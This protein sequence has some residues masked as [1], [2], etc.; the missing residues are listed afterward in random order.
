MLRPTALLFWAPL[1][2]PRLY[3]E[4]TRRGPLH[5]ARLCLVP[6]LVAVAA[7]AADFLFY[8]Q[9]T[10]TPYN[11]FKVNILHNLGSFYGS[12]PPYWYLSHALL[13]PTQGDAL[14]A[15]R[16]GAAAAAGRQEAPLLD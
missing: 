3:T 16:A 10:L 5:L 12:N 8:G 1:T 2:L 9:L 14:P 7:V 15:A 6:G 11:F 13:P 4:L